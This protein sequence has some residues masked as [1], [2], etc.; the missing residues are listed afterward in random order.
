MYV[1]RRVISGVI[2]SVSLYCE[3]L[4][5]TL[6]LG[7]RFVDKTHNDSRQTAGPNLVLSS[8]S[9]HWGPSQQTWAAFPAV[10]SRKRRL[11]PQWRHVWR[12][13][14]GSKCLKCQFSL[15]RHSLL[16]LCQGQCADGGVGLSLEEKCWVWHAHVAENYSSFEMGVTLDCCKVLPVYPPTKQ[17]TD[18]EG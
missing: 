18:F 11:P 14:G 4:E 2:V 3:I 10:G 7:S 13:Y 12:M 6:Y 16:S 17:P 8:L 9:W 5:P 1:C 15:Q